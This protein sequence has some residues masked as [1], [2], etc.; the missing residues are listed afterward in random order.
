MAV[1]P[2]QVWREDSQVWEIIAGELLLQCG[3]P[4][5]SEPRVLVTMARVRV[6]DAMQKVRDSDPDGAGHALIGAALA[7][8]LADWG[9]RLTGTTIEE[10][11]EQLGEELSG[12]VRRAT[13]YELA[14]LG[15][16][17]DKRLE[18]GRARDVPSHWDLAVWAGGCASGLSDRISRRRERRDLLEPDAG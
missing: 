3:T 18:P 5:A 4:V 15:A 1:S 6:E 2:E 14:S 9:E 10:Y 16:A 11:G 17:I 12:R 13:T 8:G 7:L